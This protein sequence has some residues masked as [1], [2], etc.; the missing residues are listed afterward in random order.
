MKHAEFV[1]YPGCYLVYE[2]LL[3]E[4]YFATVTNQGGKAEDRAWDG[5][6]VSVRA[7]A[8]G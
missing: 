4:R 6:R 3:T 7:R 5:V 1:L 2:K 8:R